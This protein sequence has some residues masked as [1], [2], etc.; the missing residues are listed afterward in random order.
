MKRM[1][2]VSGKRRLGAGLAVTTAV[3]W[4][5]LPVVLK[6]LLERI[7]AFTIVWFR[8]LGASLLLSL[9]IIR[10]YGIA[11][12]FKARGVVILLTLITI[13]GLGGNYVTY[14]LG[15][16]HMS[17][18]MAVV[19]IQVAPM[20]LLLGGL[21]IFREKFSPL[22]WGGLVLLLGGLGLFFNRRLGEM[23]SGINDLS[24]GAAVII[25][26]ALV[27]TAYALAQKQ[28]LRYFPSEIVM[29]RIYLGGTLLFLPLAH[30]GRILSLDPVRLGLLVFCA[31]NT[32]IAYGCFSEALD[33]L[34]ASRVSLV[35]AV[36]PLVTLAA[37]AAGAALFPHYL[38]PEKLDALSMT[39]ACLVV[40]GSMLG[41]FARAPA[42]RAGEG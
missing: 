32:I 28:L 35:V 16:Q 33:H 2:Q 14:A 19:M 37:A 10:R 6:V 42:L 24:I 18:G 20:M 7:D 11:P 9:F 15:V 31:V 4:G 23:L 8:F 12:I 1:H 38:A 21:F 22:Q 40:A 39:G 25:I 26:S 34:E 5:I 30:P 27:W 3:F 29:V 13:I 41:S 36:T 17:P